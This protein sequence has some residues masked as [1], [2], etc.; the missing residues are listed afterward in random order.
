MSYS[1]YPHVFKPI[2]IN[3]LTIKNRIH[4][5]PMV[6]CV[7]TADGEVNQE[8][9]DW[10]GFQARTGAG[11]ITI[12]DTQIDTE[13]A[14]CFYG[15]LDVTHDKY[16]DGLMLICEEAHRYDCKL[17]IE[18]SHG[19]RGANPKMNTLPAFAPSNLP[20]PG[21]QPILKVMDDDDR[22]WV[23][24]RWAEC[25]VRCQESGFDMVMIHCAHNNLLG[26]YLSPESNLRTDEFGGC[27]ENRMRFPLQVLESVRAAVGPRFPLELRVS[28][29][30]MTE[31]GLTFEDTLEFLKKAQQYVDLVCLSRGT[32]FSDAAIKYLCPSYLMPHMI[33]ADYAKKVRDAVKIPVQVVG[34]IYDLKDAEQVLAEGK[35]DIAGIC[36]SFMA[37]PDLLIN[38]AK[39]QEEKTRPCLRCMDGCGAVYLGAPVRCAVNPILARETRFRFIPRADVRKK[40]YVVGSGPAGMQAAET[41]LRRGHDVTILDKADRLG[42]KLHDAGALEFKVDMRKYRD[43]FVRQTESGGATIRLNTAVTPDLIRKE[44]PDAVIVATGADYIRPNLPGIDNKSV[45]MAKDVD[46]GRVEL[47]QRVVV[48][49]GG[50]TGVETALQ[51]ARSGKDV[52]VLDMIP[53]EDFAGKQFY[54]I[55]CSLMDEI[56]T[57]GVKFAGS[58]KIV[59]FKDCGVE[60][61]DANGVRMTMD[62]DNFVIA[63]GL[64]ADNR[65]YEELFEIMP[66]D[67]YAVGDCTGPKT[68]T[69]A[70]FSAFNIAVDV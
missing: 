59:G 28:I 27:L 22:E 11:Y 24:N 56:R 48:C 21:C 42:G 47:G 36:R 35:A 43:W 4:F 58:K 1:D 19:G 20:L 46:E 40:V 25:A 63:F 53:E 69:N 2:T 17:S 68:I 65:L 34:N 37:G 18:L 41:L 54:I 50:L 12:G 15:E 33:N 16:K 3:G 45:V 5:T 14:R 51:L 66:F 61:E 6:A 26:S 10:I 70:T 8:M 30:E 55:R 13:R 38:A 32:V 67:V 62:A 9:I 64:K 57:A 23:R 52:T 29:N 60:V 44:K 31:K 7:T 49:G 39:G